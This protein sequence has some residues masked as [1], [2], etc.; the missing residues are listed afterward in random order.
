MRLVRRFGASAIRSGLNDAY[1]GVMPEA[2][3]A[4][5]QKS[6]HARDMI[7]TWIREGA[8]WQP[9][10]VMASKVSQPTLILHGDVD[11]RVPFQVAEDLACAIGPAQ[12]IKLHGAGHWPFVSHSDLVADHFRR[13][14]VG[15]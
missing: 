2:R 13:F 8:H 1:G 10:T 15:G 3:A 11:T 14:L 7:E 9:S 12:L 4:S 6:L 5:F